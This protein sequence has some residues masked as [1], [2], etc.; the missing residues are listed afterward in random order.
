MTGYAAEQLLV[1]YNPLVRR[2]IEL[3]A[4][5]RMWAGAQ[6]PTLSVDDPAVRDLVRAHD[7]VVALGGDGTMLRAGRLTAPHGGQVLGIN[8]GRLGFL[9]EVQP[10]AWRAA[11]ERVVAGEGWSE[12]RMMLRI[13]HVRSGAV[14]SVEESLNEAV[15]GRGA[16][17]RMSRLQAR[18]NG[19]PLTTYVADGLICATP[20]GSTA[21]ALAAGGPILPPENENILLVPIAPHMSMERTIVLPGSASLEIE[22]AVDLEHPASLSVD[23]QRETLLARGDVVRA[24]RS[25]NVARFLRLRAPHYFFATLVERLANGRGSRL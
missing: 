18:I 12:A 25:P 17:A 23:G 6:V 4:E 3:A 10:E 21:Y 8:F 14:L 13:E 11:L 22:P 5:I 19:D 24:T 7:L 9:P 20:T 2:A 15:V 16:Q 1:L